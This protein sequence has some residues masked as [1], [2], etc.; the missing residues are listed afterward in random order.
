MSISFLKDSGTRKWLMQVL[1]VL[2]FFALM[3]W[4]AWLY[5]DYEL[6]QTRKQGSHFSTNQIT[7]FL[8]NK[9]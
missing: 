1:I 9:L 2:L 3:A 4:V 8:N 6:R 5:Y 7:P